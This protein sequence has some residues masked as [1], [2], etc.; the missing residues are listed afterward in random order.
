MTSG[1]QVRPGQGQKV[2]CVAG[3]NIEPPVEPWPGAEPGTSVNSV[4]Y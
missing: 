2:D 3:D 4:Y 1:D